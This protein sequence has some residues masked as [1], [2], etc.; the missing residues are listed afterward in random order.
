MVDAGAPW[1]PLS[2]K[3]KVLSHYVSNY[4]LMQQFGGK[5]HTLKKKKI[6]LRTNVFFVVMPMGEPFLVYNELIFLPICSSKNH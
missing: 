6:Q 4:T 5:V 1:L 2:L 3:T